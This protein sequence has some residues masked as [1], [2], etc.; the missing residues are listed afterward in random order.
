M[1]ITSF[2][3]STGLPLTTIFIRSPPFLYF[4]TLNLLVKI[5]LHTSCFAGA[6]LALASKLLETSIFHHV[7]YLLCLIVFILRSFIRPLVCPAHFCVVALRVIG[8][9]LGAL[10]IRQRCP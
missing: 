7:A 2:G 5:R 8:P 4:G 3:I 9:C 10:Q 1:V 6:L